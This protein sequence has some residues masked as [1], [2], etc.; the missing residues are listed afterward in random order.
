MLFNTQSVHYDSEIEVK[1]QIIDPNGI[2][3]AS[4][5]SRA[6]QGL[7]SKD[8]LTL[9]ERE[10]I[11]FQMTE[12]MMQDLNRSLEKQIAKV[13]KVDINSNTPSNAAYRLAE[14]IRDQPGF[15]DVKI[16]R[17]YLN[18]ADKILEAGKISGLEDPFSSIKRQ[19]MEKKVAKEFIQ[20]GRVTG[21][22]AEWK[23]G[24]I[25]AGDDATDARW[26]PINQ[27]G[28]YGLR[29]LT[30]DVI[31]QA[32]TLRKSENKRAQKTL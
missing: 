4:V 1:L 32:D 11:W 6:T 26:V 20:T 29:P 23:S 2:I 24:D 16:P 27:I 25:V 30:H 21:L 14:V 12:S 28:D 10:M 19:R 8:H 5:F 9:S 7:T 13:L 18:S 3:K 22:V 31:L 15:V 17:T